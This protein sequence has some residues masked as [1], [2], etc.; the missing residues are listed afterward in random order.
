[1]WDDQAANMS[2]WTDVDLLPIPEGSSTPDS[3]G[4]YTFYNSLDAGAP[5]SVRLNADVLAFPFYENADTLD[6]RVGD[7]DSWE[8]WDDAATGLDGELQLEI[9]STMD[10]PLLPTAIWSDWARF[11]AGEYFARAW[12][13]RAILTAP[14]GQD[15]GVE[16]LS[17]TGD[18]INKFDAGQ[19]VTYN[20]NQMRIYF[21]MKFY[22]IPA[23][24]VTI[25][26]ALST[27]KI[28]VSKDPALKTREFFTLEIIDTGGAHPTNARTFDWH[29]QGY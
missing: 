9:R 26:N 23:I 24:V 7:V 12:N 15:I 18:F 4:I 27:D 20:A 21:R 11:I 28:I 13:F 1:L 8:S 3:R 6:E 25:Q 5:F 19:D 17:I 29:A 22:T 14:A 10:D 2:T 16:T